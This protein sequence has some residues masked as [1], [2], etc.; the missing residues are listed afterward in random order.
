MYVNNSLCATFYCAIRTCPR[1]FADMSHR[2]ICI[3]ILWKNNVHSMKP[4]IIRE[5]DIKF[6]LGIL[7]T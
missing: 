4:S 7:L 6:P 3:F 1:Q 5:Y 2:R